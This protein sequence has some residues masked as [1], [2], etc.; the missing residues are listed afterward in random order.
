M[1]DRRAMWYSRM[2]INSVRL[3]KYADGG[4]WAGVMSDHSIT[5]FNPEK[6]DR[7]DYF[8]YALREQGI[9]TKLSPHFGVKIQPGDR[10]RV[11][12]FDEIGRDRSRVDAG[13]GAIYLAEELQ[14]MHIE[15]LVKTLEHRNPYTGLR[16]AD[17][18][19][20]WC[21]EFFNEDSVLFYGTNTRLLTLP[22][23]RMRTA[24][25]FSE[26]LLARYGSEEAWREAWGD[27]AI[28]GEGGLPRAPS[29]LQNLIDATRLVGELPAESL[30]A[31]SVV[32]WGQPWFFDAATSGS[33]EELA[34]MKVRFTDT[35]NFLVLL[36]DEFHDRCR[37]AI[38]ATGFQGL[39]MASNWQA[40]NNV[41]HYLNLLSDSRFD[42]IDRHNYYPGPRRALRNPRIDL[43][44]AS[45]L[46][47]PGAGI[48]SSGLQ[49]VGG[50]P[51]ML[52]EWIH[53]Q[54]SEW[55]V[56]GPALI[57]AYGMGLNGWDVSY[58]FQNSDFAGFT[59]RMGRDAWEVM[60]PQ[61]VGVFPAIARQVRRGD[62][63]RASLEIPLFVNPSALREGRSTASFVT[64]QRADVKSFDTNEVPKD[65]LAV[66]AVEVRF[67]EDAEVS[68]PF[69][70][71]DYRDESGA[72]I[73]STGQLRWMPG[74]SPL[75]AAGYLTMDTSV[76]VAFVGFAPEAASFALGEVILEPDPGFAAI[77][78]TAAG[79]DEVIV[80]NGDLLLVAMAR[81]RNADARYNPDETRLLSVGEGPLLL[82]PVRATVSL[83]GQFQVE[84]LDHDGQPTGQ[85]LDVVEGSF[86][87]DGARDRTPY[88]RILRQ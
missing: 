75:A 42:I 58:I 2:G 35:M 41:P 44:P 84:K 50:L 64:I 78:L 70:I 51:F 76:T 8:V 74:S 62:V 7:M 10:A 72:L 3:H 23:I 55:Q 86:R 9:F 77:Y 53:E 46:A 1:A 27:A 60:L 32:P 85:F 5:E 79:P 43:N 56:E 11:P 82:E 16:Y 66:G 36:M 48:L 38:R 71:A 14:E 25:R 30:T 49:Q 88:Y 61:V 68:P 83:P 39:I 18:P 6:I 22:T 12:W 4:D 57:G 34:P 73:S 69:D 20:I 21:I 54:P 37:D 17:D 45:M 47:D 52:S 28:I 67:D 80:G 33:D 65:A 13:H 19:A 24:D 31:G 40:G 87:I 81:G 63:A 26:W 29:H 15:I 59:Q